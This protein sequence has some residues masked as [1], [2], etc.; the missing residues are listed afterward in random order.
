MENLENKKMNIAFVCD[1]ISDNKAGVIVSTLRFAEMLKKHGHKIIFIAAKNPDSPKED[2]FR[3]FKVY[4]F[5]SILIPKS[6]GE[7][8][9]AFPWFSDL[10]NI[11]I[12]EKID[13]V[14]LILPTPLSAISSRVAKSLNIGL[15]SHSHSQPENIF[16][17]LPKFLRLKFIDNLYNK[18]LSWIYKKADAII[19]PSIFAKKHLEKLNK[20]IREEIISNG[21]DRSFFKKI[22]QYDDFIDKF[23]L[24]KNEKKIIYVGRLH[25]E[26]SVETLIK[27]MYYVSK[28]LEDVHLYIVGSG[29]QRDKLERLSKDLKLNKKVTFLG[30]ISNEDLVKAYSFCDLF[31]LPSL[32]ELEGMVVLEAIS[33]GLPIV[34]ANS[35]QSASVDFVKENGL[36]FDPENEEDL[37]LKILWMF[38]NP[39]KMLEM[40]KRS[41]E[42]SEKYDINESVRKLEDLYLEIY[43]KHK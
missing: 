23:N 13:I 30:K 14:H 16:L 2:Y 21:V 38:N 24:L 10:K 17:H 39:S 9:L 3:D 28:N 22:S 12:R 33:C 4:R 11:F 43:L 34:I 36:L 41:L 19:Y 7:W 35:K 31:V 5:H 40:S 27:S 8:R 37:C 15:I 25:P 6:E 29:H 32:A 18:Y 26:K 42:L 1:P 20:G